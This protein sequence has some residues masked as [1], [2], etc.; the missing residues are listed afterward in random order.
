MT[1]SDQ[2]ALGDAIR[3]FLARIRPYDPS[4][5]AAVLELRLG[6]DGD[7]FRLTARAVDALTSALAGYTDPD[8]CGACTS[9]GQPLNRDLHC[10]HCG[11]VDGIFGQTLAAHL[12]DRA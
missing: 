10:V 1:S 12:A 4:P 3:R 5:D 6:R 8:D 2:A 11:R 9:C 7:T